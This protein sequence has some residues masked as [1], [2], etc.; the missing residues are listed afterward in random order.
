M[1]DAKSIFEALKVR[2]VG[3]LNQVSAELM[4]SPQFVKAMAGAM[5]GKQ[6]LDQAVGRV[7]KNMNIPTRTEFKRAV[8]R[9]EVL[10]RELAQLK[11]S[12]KTASRR[13]GPRRGTKK[14]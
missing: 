8:G 14:R 7:L 3:V 11:A 13:P 4:E 5:R 9:I 2:G 10:E 6:R 12:V 1:K